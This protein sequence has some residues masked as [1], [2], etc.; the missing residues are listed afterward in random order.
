M[1]WIEDRREHL[2]ASVHCRDHFYD[3]TLSADKDG[4]LLGVEGEIYIDA[5][6]Y[7]LWPT[8]SFM[9]ASMASRNL[10]GALSHPAP[11]R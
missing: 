7:S 8:G 6:A 11:R 2:L 9:E 10:T 4:T 5:G 1:R 3:L